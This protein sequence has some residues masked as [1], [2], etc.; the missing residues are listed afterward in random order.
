MHNDIE[1]IQEEVQFTD[2][3]ITESY[4]DCSYSP[5]LNRDVEENDSG[6]PPMTTL[7]VKDFAG[8]NR[9]SSLHFSLNQACQLLYYF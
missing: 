5:L 3:F 6:E 2:S 1:D 7:K 4:D 9:L 8:L